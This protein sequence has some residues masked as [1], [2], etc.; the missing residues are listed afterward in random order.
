MLASLLAIAAAFAQDP[1]LQAAPSAGGPA[2]WPVRLVVAEDERGLH[3][4]DPHGE[5]LPTADALVLVGRPDLALR[6]AARRRV[7]Y[8][9]IPDRVPPAEIAVAVAAH[10]ARWQRA[11]PPP[12]ALDPHGVVTTEGRIVGVPELAARFGDPRAARELRVAHTAGVDVGQALLGTGI[13]AM[14]VSWLTIVSE[15]QARSIRDPGHAGVGLLFGAGLAIVGG[16]VL[17]A[18]YDSRRPVRHWRYLDLDERVE[19]WNDEH[20]AQDVAAV[21]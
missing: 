21:P 3:L 20:A 2:F 7:A 1:Y 9:A 17:G 8:D 15:S 11:V 14:G 6:Y 19:D 16:G 18:S 12:L 4:L 5:P 10:N 13:V